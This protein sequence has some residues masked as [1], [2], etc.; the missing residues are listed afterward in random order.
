MYVQLLLSGLIYHASVFNTELLA[1]GTGFMWLLS[2]HRL[3]HRDCW[4]WVT[5]LPLRYMVSTIL[6]N[7]PTTDEL[8]T[9]A[10]KTSI[11]LQQRSDIP[12]RHSLTRAMGYR[13]SAL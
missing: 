4:K 10:Q 2:V 1:Y 9:Q 3:I 12:H 7:T 13:V 11:T 5:D 8:H 6:R